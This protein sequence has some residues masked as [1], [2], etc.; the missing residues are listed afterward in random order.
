MI[1]G[2]VN[3]ILE[4]VISLEVYGS[5]KRVREM[6][7]VID[8]GFTGYLTLPPPVIS[9]LGLSSIAVGSLTLADGSEVISDVCAATVFWD[10]QMRVVEVDSL[11]MEVL[12]GMSLLDGYDLS[13]RVAV[14]GPVTIKPISL[15]QSQPE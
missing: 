15:S 13:V 7:A 1:T 5:Q 12:V 8:T 9:A 14:G 11:E 6:E 2:Y 10:G 3:S 4:A